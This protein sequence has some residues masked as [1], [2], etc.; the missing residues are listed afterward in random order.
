MS[1]I[2]VTPNQEVVEQ[3]TSKGILS[4]AKVFLYMFM[5][6]AITTVVSFGV[7]GIIAYAIVN[8][9]DTTVVANTYIGLMIAS[10]ISLFILM[11]VINFVV[12]RGKHSVIVP[13][14]IYSVLMG[15]LLSSFTL[16]IDWRILG[17][18]F[19]ITSGIFLLMTLIAVLT[20]GNLSPLLMVGMGLMI[21]AG[22]L[23]LINWLIQS[24]TIM[25]IVSFALFAAIMFI[26][27]FDIWNIKKICERGQMT[28][29]MSMYCAFTLY[30]DFIYILIKVLWFLILIF[31]RKN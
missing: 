15:V 19:G 28:P 23:A 5:F 14:I 25:W 31:G 4:F 27:M 1:Q 30:V 29:N 3:K 2:Y 22:I 9:A 21:G 26:T 6:L 17:L 12:L 20:K 13:A 8:G 16:F 10:G 24:D 11:I 7:G 18:A